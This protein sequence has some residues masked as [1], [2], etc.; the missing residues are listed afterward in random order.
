M[1]DLR[2]EEISENLKRE[3]WQQLSRENKERKKMLYINFKKARLH[4][5][6][7]LLVLA[8]IIVGGPWSVDSHNGRLGYFNLI[9]SD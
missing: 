6:V 5:C 3:V 9:I 1:R 4:I 2:G 8:V 7:G